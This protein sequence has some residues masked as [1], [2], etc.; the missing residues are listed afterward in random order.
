MTYYFGSHTLD[1]FFLFL[2]FICNFLSFIFLLFLFFFPF[3]C[4]LSFVMLTLQFLL[5]SFGQ[6]YYN[7][8]S[9]LKFSKCITQLKYSFKLL[10]EIRKTE[11]S[12]S[13]FRSESR[14]HISYASAKVRQEHQSS[15]GNGT[16]TLPYIYHETELKKQKEKKALLNF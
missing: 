7:R 8:S 13:F 3:T 1:L 9:Q 11:S 2:S 10:Q 12:V 16:D 5:F 15:L 14:D 6:Q 4:H